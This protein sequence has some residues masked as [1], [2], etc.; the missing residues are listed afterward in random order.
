MQIVMQSKRQNPFKTLYYSASMASCC[1]VS[2]IQTDVTNTKQIEHDN[3]LWLTNYVCMYVCP[4]LLNNGAEGAKCEYTGMTLL[5][6]GETDQFV[7]M[8]ALCS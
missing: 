4:D 7:T 6:T 8:V 5:G 2:C 3:E 1:K